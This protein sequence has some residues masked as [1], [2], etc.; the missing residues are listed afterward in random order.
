MVLTAFGLAGALLL[1]DSRMFSFFANVIY[2]ATLLLL[3]ITIFVASDVKAPVHGWCLVLLAF[4]PAE[5]TKTAT[6]L[7]LANL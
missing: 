6:A 7:A 4:K 3:V 1:L 2:I 5:L